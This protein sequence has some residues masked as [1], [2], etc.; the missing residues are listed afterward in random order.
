MDRIENITVVGA[1]Y[2]G[3]GIAQSFARGGYRVTI[4]DV[5]KSAAEQA[6][7]RLVD[8]AAEY[9]SDGLFEPGSAKLVRENLVAADS[10]EKAVQGADFIEEAVFEDSEIKRSV[11][12]VISDSAK[13]DAIIGTNT[14]TI[15]AAELEVSVINPERFLT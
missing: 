15:S 5:S 8:E 7:T 11:L 2:M 10:I 13:P 4:A 6:L 3:G 14:S 12:K 1:G 9:E